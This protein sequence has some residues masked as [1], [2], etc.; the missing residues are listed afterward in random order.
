MTS[1]PTEDLAGVHSILVIGW[2]QF[3]CP[4]EFSDEL[5]GVMDQDR[6]MLGTD[7]QSLSPVVQDHQRRRL[8][9][10]A[11][12]QTAFFRDCLSHPSASLPASAAVSR[13]EPGNLVNK[14]G[15]S[16]TPIEWLLTPPSSRP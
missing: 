5:H 13:R 3:F 12:G 2:T 4:Y 6:Q 14:K 9:I 7:P 1:W 16:Q 11:T 10:S 15:G 8:V